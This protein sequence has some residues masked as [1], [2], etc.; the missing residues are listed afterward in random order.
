MQRA[1]DAGFDVIEIHNAHG[2]L[3]SEFV[4]PA[5]NKRTDI[6][7]GSFENRIRLTLE[8]IELTRSIMPSGIP[9]FTRIS[10][11]DWLE[12]EDRESWTVDDSAELAKSLIGKGVD[13]IDVSSGGLDH[14]Q[15]IKPAEPACFS[16]GG[17]AY[18]AVGS[19]PRT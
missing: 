18:Q 1:L 3:L 6:Y 9:L 13:F 2:Y 17:K 4:S 8:I 14:K 11:T 5:S 10:A 19:N 16:V 7:G 12:E 15:R